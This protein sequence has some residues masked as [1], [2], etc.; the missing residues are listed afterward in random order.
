M[1]WLKLLEIVNKSHGH[2]AL[3]KAQ[4]RGSTLVQTL[5]FV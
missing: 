4:R 5:H 3:G 1:E 2:V